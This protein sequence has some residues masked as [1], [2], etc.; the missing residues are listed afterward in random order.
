MLSGNPDTFAIWCDPVQS[1]STDRFKNGCFAYFIGS[2]ILWSLNSTL[3]VDLN[4]LSGLHCIKDSIEDDRLFS[5]PSAEAHIALYAQAFPSM[6]SDVDVSDYTHLVSVGGLLDEGHNVFLVESGDQ[7][8]LIYGFN[9]DLSSV[10]EIALKRGEFQDVVL[11]AA[12]N[13]H[14]CE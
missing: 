12:R 9:D 1:W 2:E 6:D 13:W 11:E 7:A 4:L 10:R 8:K 3:G 14:S 5:L